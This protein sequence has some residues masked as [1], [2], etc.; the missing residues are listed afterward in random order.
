MNGRAMLRY[1]EDALMRLTDE[2]IWIT[3][4]ILLKTAAKEATMEILINV[5]R[6]VEDIIRQVVNRGTAKNGL[7]QHL[8]VFKNLKRFHK[9]LVVTL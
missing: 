6:A 9:T 2:M 3:M 7:A 1:E 4:E 8:V 5:D